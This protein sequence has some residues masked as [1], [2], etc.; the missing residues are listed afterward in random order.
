MPLK[1]IGTDTDRSGTYDFLLAF[2][3]NTGLYLAPFPGYSYPCL[4]N[5][6]LIFFL[7]IFVKILPFTMVASESPE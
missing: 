4:S 2:H 7:S 1:I 5:N 3:N 6:K